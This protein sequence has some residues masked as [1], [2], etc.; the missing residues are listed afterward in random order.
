MFPLLMQASFAQLT[1][2]SSKKHVQMDKRATSGSPCRTNR[3]RGEHFRNLR[4]GRLLSSNRNYRVS[5]TWENPT[6]TNFGTLTAEWSMDKYLHCNKSFTEC[7]TSNAGF[8]HCSIHRG[9][10]KN[11]T[12]YNA[13][14][15][16]FVRIFSFPEYCNEDKRIEETLRM[17]NFTSW[18]S[19][20]PKTCKWHRPNG[21]SDF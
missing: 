5:H 13:C 7:A 17:R 12:T 20:V 3:F 19:R 9:S 11:G 6:P 18:T 15:A 1:T 21:E 2:I 8:G 14:H 4:R 10:T 16:A